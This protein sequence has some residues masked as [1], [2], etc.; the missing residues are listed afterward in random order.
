M[1]TIANQPHETISEY[2]T[3]QEAA[4]FLT[5]RG[6]PTAKGT[7]QK[8]VTVGGGPRYQRFGN[9]ALYKPNDLIEWAQG[10][11]SAP[12]TSSSQIA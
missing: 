4:S 8:Y 10:R 5:S 9:R 3:R 2:L 6:F 12:V 1:L 7:L 11:L